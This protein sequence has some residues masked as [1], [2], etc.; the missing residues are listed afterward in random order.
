[1]RRQKGGKIKDVTLTQVGYGLLG[2]LLRSPDFEG[3]QI[4]AKLGNYLV[5]W[6]AHVPSFSVSVGESVYAK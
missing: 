1:L 6:I 4:G 5:K 2:D 3:T